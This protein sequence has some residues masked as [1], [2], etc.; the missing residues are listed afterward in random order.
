[1]DE[2]M[3]FGSSCFAS[4][5]V[6]RESAVAK[7]PQA[8]SFAQAATVPT[9][10]F[11]VYYALKHLANLQPG[12]RIL[13]HGA[14]G[15]VGIAAIQ[16]A[17][18]LG[19]EIFVTAGS[20]EKRDFV[21][22]LGA[23]HVSDSRSFAFADDI[24]AQ[25]CGEGVDVVLNS[26]AGEAIN[27]N[28][29]VL[30]PFGRF[31]ELGKRDFYENTH[32]GLRPFKDNIN[33]YGIDTDQL[34]TARPELAAR[35]FE[36][37]MAL[38][39]EGILFPL[40]YTV[41]SAER[42]VDA[43]RYMQ[44]SKHIGKVV[45]DLA[46]AK[47]DV[48]QAQKKERLKLDA[49]GTYLITG[50]LGGFGLESAK[51]LAECGAGTLVLLGRRGMETPG[52]PDAAAQVEALGAKI[53]V[54]ACDVSDK[55]ALKKVF[56]SIKDLPP[57]KGIFHAAAVFD[58]ALL[59]NL[60]EK[61]FE[62][63]LKPKAVG[64]W[65][66]HELSAG[67]ALDFFVLYSSVTTDIGNPGQANYVAANAYLQALAAWRRRQGLPATCVNWGPI[68]DAGY[69]TRNE[70]IKD[71][72]ANRLGA[73]SLSARQALEELEQLILKKETGITVA[74]FDWG[75]LSRMLPSA[76]SARFDALRRTEG[77]G[78]SSENSTADI[79]LLI[80]DKPVEEVTKI[81]KELIIVEVAKI[82]CI[83]PERIDA[84]QP[85]SEI[86]MDSLMVVELALAIEQRM[87]VNLPAMALSEGSGSIDRI[88]TKLA[89]K[90]CGGAEEKKGDNLEMLVDAVAA[91]HNESLSAEIVAETIAEIK[92]QTHSKAR[93]IA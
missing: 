46:N 53:H 6:T 55:E 22:L 42:I 16:I 74:D 36:E 40:P 14:A 20:E 88:C 18:H 44:Q 47:I 81:V 17:R 56:A 92:S 64:A 26:L 35:L 37:V 79:H 78:G 52:A 8:W 9:A 48:E 25:T 69:L 10:F 41:F 57:L 19:A 72:L 93:R 90:L 38:F 4:H 73:K 1:G 15:G 58:D 45:V 76:K 49:Q 60:D 7:K 21:R 33:Y 39:D 2:V 83:G 63:V 84:S 87:G 70:N 28:L 51:W 34:L 54:F 12:E 65:N 27:R 11:T 80:A 66:L 13:I 43:F 62:A 50:G 5:V 68:G 67:T 82:L 31:L 24:L 86:G 61:R 3:G 71:S 23:E 29:R 85:L 30:K 75:S 59:A 89:E 77:A 91:Q 32:I